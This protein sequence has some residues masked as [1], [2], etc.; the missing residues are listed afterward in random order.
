[1]SG[2][3]RNRFVALGIVLLLVGYIFLSHQLEKS[4][5]LST[6]T[7]YGRKA[8]GIS[9]F[10]D[11]I[12]RLGGKAMDIQSSFLEKIPADL[13]A[14]AILAPQATITPRE[15]NLLRV[16]V[17]EGGTLI[18]SAHTLE[19]T[20]QIQ[21]ILTTQLIS[22]GFVEISDFKNRELLIAKP[23]ADSLFFRKDESYAFYGLVQ[24]NGCEK[25]Q[26]ECHYR[27][28]NVGQGRVHVFA[29]VPPFANRLINQSDNG[30]AAIR[31]ARIIPR[32]AFDEFH[33]FFSDRTFGDL[34]ARPAFGITIVGIVLILMLFFLFAHTPLHEKH[35][36]PPPRKRPEGFHD[37]NERFIQG[38]IKKP[39]HYRENLTTYYDF[40]RRLFP[41]SQAEI[42]Q[43]ERTEFFKASREGLSES[44]FLSEA[45]KILDLHHK[46]LKRKGRITT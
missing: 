34:M 28:F 29:S 2:R 1:M 46:L 39:S 24:F 26:L 21:S 32:I 19:H 31:M 17:E 13:E 12:N 14:I 23:K 40:L 38:A 43:E 6:T 36:I 45:T 7:V 3:S 33:H 5:Q 16:F 35:L 20:A 25:G 10:M 22:V 18:L 41:E 15:A 9:V 44:Q 4:A 11:L 27:Q 42:T 37:F 30:A 8:I